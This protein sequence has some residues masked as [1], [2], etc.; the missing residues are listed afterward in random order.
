MGAQLQRQTHNYTW[1]QFRSDSLTEDSSSHTL[2]NDT[3]PEIFGFKLEFD[4]D[5]ISQ[6]DFELIFGNYN[7]ENLFKMCRRYIYF[8][9]EVLDII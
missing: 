4:Y 9:T 7:L 2:I 3:L 1:R 5:L 6:G 8:L